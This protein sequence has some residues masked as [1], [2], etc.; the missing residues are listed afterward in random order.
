[1]EDVE[2]SAEEEHHLEN[3]LNNEK[4]DLR[5]GEIW[6]DLNDNQYNKSELTRVVKEIRSDLSK[7]KEDNEQI[8]KA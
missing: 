4:G 7:V 2:M 8:L 1:M 5:D 3:P 6:V